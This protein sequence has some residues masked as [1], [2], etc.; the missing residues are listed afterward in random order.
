MAG[1]LPLYIIGY[2]SYDGSFDSCIAIRTLVMRMATT[3]CALLYGHSR[4]GAA[5]AECFFGCIWTL[6]DFMW[7]AAPVGVF[8][9][10]CP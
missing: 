1:E 8:Y 5:G 2:F 10:L 9:G 4:Y 3:V 7:K 6:W